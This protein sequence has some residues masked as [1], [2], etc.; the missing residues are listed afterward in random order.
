MKYIII[1]NELVEKIKQTK[2]DDNNELNP[3]KGIINNKEIYYLPDGIID[4]PVFEKV[5]ADF[6]VC[7]IKDISII[8]CK[9]FDGNDIE[10]LLT[11]TIVNNEETTI[12]LVDGKEVNPRDLKVKTILI[13]AKF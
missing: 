3:I 10:I 8:E 9:Y 13:E 2:F 4:N 1:P 6:E 12:Y 11:K 5:L 7:E